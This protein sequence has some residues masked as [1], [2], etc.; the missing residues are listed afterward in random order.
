MAEQLS[1]SDVA[2]IRGHAG[3]YGWLTI[4]PGPTQILL[5]CDHVDALAAARKADQER[6]AEL[7]ELLSRVHGVMDRVMVDFQHERLEPRLLVDW[8]WVH[9]AMHDQLKGGGN[10]R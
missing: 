10:E 6:I 4:Q 1:A 7:E 9:Q 2:E 3:R 5:L 8:T